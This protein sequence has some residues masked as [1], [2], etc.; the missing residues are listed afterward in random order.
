[1]IALAVF[2]HSAESQTTI[3]PAAENWQQQIH[4]LA[5]EELKNTGIPSLQIAI[6]R[7]N[8]VIFEQAYGFA[9]LENKVVATQNTKYRIASMSK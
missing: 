9:D 5:S 7:D 3:K 6:G 1:M 4:N 8:S 2:S